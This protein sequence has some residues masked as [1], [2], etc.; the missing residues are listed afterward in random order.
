MKE[1]LWALMNQTIEEVQDNF[2]WIPFSSKIEADM[3][4]NAI[5]QALA[6]MR[7]VTTTLYEVAGLSYSD[8]NLAFDV[9]QMIEDE[10]FN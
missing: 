8:W 1:Y 9:L 3:R 10:V 5:I 7:G 4:Y 6:Y 2:D